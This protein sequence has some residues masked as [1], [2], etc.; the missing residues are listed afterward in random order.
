MPITTEALSRSAAYRPHPKFQIQDS[1]AKIFAGC[2][3]TQK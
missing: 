1:R 3:E 2:E